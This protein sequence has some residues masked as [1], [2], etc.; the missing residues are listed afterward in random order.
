MKDSIMHIGSSTIPTTYQPCLVEQPANLAAYDPA[1][2]GIAFL[3]DLLVTPTFPTGMQQ[4]DPIAVRHAQHSGFCQKPICPV[5][6]HFEQ[7]E[8]ASALGQFREP[9]QPIALQPAIEGTVAYSFQ[10]KQD[11][12]SH[13]FTWIKIRLDMFS[14]PFH[15]IIDPNEQRNDKIL[16]G[17]GSL[18]FRLSLTRIVSDVRDFFNTSN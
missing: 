14:H 15:S 11:P 5:S 17:H 3:P 7:T 2:V 16:G 1:T 4:L 12:Q 9:N 6:M 13:N 10:R 18:S 8:Q